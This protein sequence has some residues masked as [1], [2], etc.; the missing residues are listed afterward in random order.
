MV[1]LGGEDLKGSCVVGQDIVGGDLGCED[2]Y[3]SYKGV[4]YTGGI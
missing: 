4:T 1:S 3:T 2:I